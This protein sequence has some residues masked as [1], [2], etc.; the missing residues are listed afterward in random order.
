MIHKVISYTDVM[1]DE[2][3]SDSDEDPD[4][5]VKDDDKQGKVLFKICHKWE[6]WNQ[7]QKRNKTMFSMIDITTSIIIMLC[8]LHE[9]TLDVL[10]QYLFFSLL[11]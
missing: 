7:K 1:M 3:D 2:D 8:Y 6:K 5:F 11:S 9:I 4:Q 10:Y